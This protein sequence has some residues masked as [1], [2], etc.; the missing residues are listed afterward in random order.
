MERRLL[1]AVW[2]LGDGD[3]PNQGLLLVT[4]RRRIRARIAVEECDK[5][6]PGK[7]LASA[8][9]GTSVWRSLLFEQ[10]IHPVR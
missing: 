2:Q 8:R 9:P 5:R 3:A 6:R 4:P 7:G 10:Y 1:Y